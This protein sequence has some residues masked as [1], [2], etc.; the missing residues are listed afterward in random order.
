MGI[1]WRF[2]PP[3][4]GLEADLSKW[5]VLPFFSVG[6]RYGYNQL[7]NDK[8]YLHDRYGIDA[9]C[10]VQFSEILITSFFWVSPSAVIWCLAACPMSCWR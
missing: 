8:D 6:Q 9:N 1:F 3:A 7:M 2:L 4:V 10:S 5:M